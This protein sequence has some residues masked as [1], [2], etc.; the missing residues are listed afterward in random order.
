M[1][2]TSILEEQLAASTALPTLWPSYPTGRY[3]PCRSPKT[4]ASMCDSQGSPTGKGRMPTKS[5][6]GR[7]ITLRSRDRILSSTKNEQPTAIANTM[8]ESHPVKGE[9]QTPQWT[10]QT[11]ILL[12]VVRIS[13]VS[14]GGLG[15]GCGND[16]KGHSWASILLFLNLGVDDTSMFN[17]SKF[18]E[19]SICALSCMYTIL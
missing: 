10:F 8:A 5:R 12:H 15:R 16:R 18:I 3:A 13:Q 6:T 2:G 7:E 14:F 9:I 11:K 19:L 17:L 4:H 1:I